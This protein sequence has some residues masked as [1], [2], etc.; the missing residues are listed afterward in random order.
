ME[1]YIKN[2]VFYFSKNT[3]EQIIEIINNLHKNKHS[4]RLFYGDQKTGKSWNEENDTIGIVGISNGEI[5]IPLL[6]KTSRSRYGSPIS[7][8]SIVKLIDIKTKEI[9]YIHP[10][11]NQS[12]F[13][14]ISCL[15]LQDFITFANCKDPKQAEKLA[16]FMN[17]IKNQK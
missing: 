4:I 17:G 2:G 8:D 6:M 15:V 11:F 16:S 7:D 1:N 12:K 14:A 3:P 13:T 9:L 10:T 5:R